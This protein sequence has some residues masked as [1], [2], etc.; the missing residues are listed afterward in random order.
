MHHRPDHPAAAPNTTPGTPDVPDAPAPAGTL[1]ASDAD[2]NTTL[3]QLGDALAEGALDTPEY[4][5]RLEQA[6]TATTVGQLTALT[7]DL[8]V[9]RTALAK[10]E[11]A[12]KAAQAQADKHEWR[13]EW[14]YWGGGALI[15]TVI[16]TI[17]CVRE[18]DLTFFWPVWPLGI[19]GA[20]LLSYALWP[21]NKDS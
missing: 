20:I 15:M 16:W 1:R 21:D 10:A 7:A 2:R 6:V 13:N 11:A 4:N 17:N 5:R 9:S 14:G 18:H 3:E 12:R 19:W 8:P